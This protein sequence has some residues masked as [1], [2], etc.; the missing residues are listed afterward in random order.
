MLQICHPLTIIPFLGALYRPPASSV[1]VFLEDFLSY[2][3]FLSSLSSSFVV[4][5]DFNIHEDS[6]S[7][8]VSELKSVFDACCLTQDIEFPTHLHV[9]TL[10]LLLAPTEFSA[11]SEVHGP[12]FISDHKIIS[13]LIDF[14]SAGNHQNK[15]VT[16]RPYL[17]INVD[18]FKEDLVASAFVANPSDDIDT[19]YEQ[20]V[21]SL[22]D[23]LDIYA[24]LKMKH[25]AK[26]APG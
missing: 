11:I 14:Q 23:L 19:I 24:P 10:D 15:V 17:K 7:P 6:T 25:L 4:C 20:Y 18:R 22:S 26:P 2:I 12:C 3:G 16:F 9:H 21:S 13:C 8:F 5:G 1:Q